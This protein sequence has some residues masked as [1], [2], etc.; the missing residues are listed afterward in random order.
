MNSI[1]GGVEPPANTAEIE[2]TMSLQQ[3]YLSGLFFIGFGAFAVWAG[4]DLAIG[5]AADMGIG[6]TP[7]ALAIGCVAIGGLLLVQAFR[8]SPDGSMARLTF[9]WRPAILVTIMVIG[10]GIL[11][12]RLGLPLT[13]AVVFFAAALS[14]EEF[15]WP[16]LFLMAVGMALLSFALFSMALKLQIPVWPF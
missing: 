8:S 1:A 10:F 2:Q 4:S 11:L 12:P 14:G 3:Q 7:R 5:T 9:A 15:S 13:V 16:L 6:Y